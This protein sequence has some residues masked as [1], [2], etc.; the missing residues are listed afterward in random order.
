M[1]RKRPLKGRPITVE[2]NAIPVVA[3]RIYLNDGEINP[4]AVRFYRNQ[5]DL[6]QE[7]LAEFF[8]VA[9]QSVAYW[10]RGVVTPGTKNRDKLHQFFVA[11]I[12][13]LQKY[14]GIIPPSKKFRRYF[15]D[16]E[17]QTFRQLLELLSDGDLEGA[18]ELVNE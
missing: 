9:A 5:H 2:P 17:A 8:N 16:G 14:D 7:M 12:R 10:E 3:P 11:S 1:P 18:K 13:M 15:E 6:T 4:D